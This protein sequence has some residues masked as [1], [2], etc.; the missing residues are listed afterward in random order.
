MGIG[1]ANVTDMVRCS[2][3]RDLL[4]RCRVRDT[5]VFDVVLRLGVVFGVMCR[6]GVM[7]VLAG[8]GIHRK[9]CQYTNQK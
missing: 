2:M 8:F 5:V 6:L 4:M 7:L 9:P 1:A 3:L